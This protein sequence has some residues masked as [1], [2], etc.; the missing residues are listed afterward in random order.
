M[1]KR[2][3]NKLL[4]V[5]HLKNY[6]IKQKLLYSYTLLIIASIVIVST[7][8]IYFSMRL[9]KEKAISYSLN[10]MKQISHNTDIQLTTLDK[11]T[12][13]FLTDQK[14][15]RF[16]NSYYDMGSA[17][18][19]KL[20]NELQSFLSNFILTNNNIESVYLINHQGDV[21]TTGD[22]WDITNP[23]YYHQEAAI[24]QG[25]LVWLKTKT[26]P[27]GNRVIPVVRQIVDLSTLKS[28]GTLLLHFREGAI[29]TLLDNEFL[30]NEGSIIVIDPEGSIVSSKEMDDEHRTI[31]PNLQQSI[32]DS[33]DYFFYKDELG[34]Y[35]YSFYQSN[36][37]NWTY[38]FKIPRS[39]LFDGINHARNW[40]IIVSI[41]F[42]IV[43]ILIVQT[44]SRSISQPIQ[45]VIKE[46]ENVE[47]SNLLVNLQYDGK[48]EL[49]VL[50]HTFNTMMN[51]IR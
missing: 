14:V 5:L 39:Y 27:M 47:K 36:Y 7:F 37:T 41:F 34:D 12:Y 43:S 32:V 49:H 16:F 24:G 4:N 23:E 31:D 30:R 6:K 22:Y 25:S 18:Y 48:D 17:D 33:K 20:R 26:S 3:I 29:R 35:F 51:R 40:I 8:A 50:T 42:I 21:V 38:L 13:I 44:I 2:I 9:H 11:N 45:Y 46:M 28:N 19:Y 1:L 15:N 10:T